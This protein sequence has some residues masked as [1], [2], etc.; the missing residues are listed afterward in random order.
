[1][2]GYSKIRNE[3]LE[4]I[5]KLKLNGTQFKIIMVIWR[6]T[7]GFQRQEYQLSETFIAKAIETDKRQTRR[8]LNELIRINIIKVIKEATFNT[9]RIISF[10]ENYDS[11]SIDRPQMV[12]KT[13]EGELDHS[14]EGEKVQISQISEGELD[15]QER[16]YLKK[17]L[18][19]DIKYNFQQ[20]I[21]LYNEICISYPRVTKLS[22]AR[23]KAIKARLNSYT[24]DDFKKLFHAAEESDFLKGKNDR[25]WSCNLDWL[26]KDTNMAKVLDGNYK[27]NKS[28]QQLQPQ[29]KVNKFNE[30]EKHGYTTDQISEL[31]KKLLGSNNN[32]RWQKHVSESIPG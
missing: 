19:K 13:S 10:N 11:W 25:N 4:S 12:N 16:K 24:E 14:P 17:S 15:H 31:E 2:D 1:M 20:I 29:S 22:D 6:F 23:K 27:N 18:K 32:G 21:D 26:I 8:E 5:Y 28:Q 3:V 7:Y 9:T 30:H